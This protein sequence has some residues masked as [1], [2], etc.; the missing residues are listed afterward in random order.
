MAIASTSTERPKE[1]QRPDESMAGSP[2]CYMTS[3][4]HIGIFDWFDGESIERSA[5]RYEGESI[6]VDPDYMDTMRAYLVQFVDH[7]M[8]VVKMN[9]GALSFFA[10]Q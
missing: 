3:G 2:P 7:Q 6:V 8:L 9:D 5:F 1:I 4:S 10:V